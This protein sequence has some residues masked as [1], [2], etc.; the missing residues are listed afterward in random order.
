MSWEETEKQRRNCRKAFVARGDGGHFGDIEVQGLAD[1]GRKGHG[2]S[3]GG[4]EGSNTAMR[5]I[6]KRRRAAALQKKTRPGV[7]GRV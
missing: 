5:C 7:P 4:L 2:S 3:I 1:L 6:E